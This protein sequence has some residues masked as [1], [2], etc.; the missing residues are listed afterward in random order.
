M[1]AAR[2]ASGAG[3]AAPA[4]VGPGGIAPRGLGLA[5]LA[6]FLWSLTGVLLRFVEA[7]STWQIIGLRSLVMLAAIALYLV[8]HHRGGVLRAI[9]AIGREGLIGGLCLGCGFAFYISAIQTTTVAN[10]AMLTAL[11]PL[12]AAVLARVI[13]GEAVA[14]RTWLYAAVAVLG[15]GAMVAE[16]AVLGGWLGNLLAL[17]AVACQAAF[18]VA[19][20]K[21]RAVD[22]MPA[23]GV[24]ALVSAAFALA[25]AGSVAV[26]TRD[27]GLI[28]VTGI[29]STLLGNLAFVRAAR[30]VGAATLALLSMAEIVMSPLWVA[31]LV[32]ELPTPWA[33]AGGALVIGAVLAQV[34]DAAR[35]SAPAPPA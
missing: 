20:R 22:M 25:M 32:S 23:I 27:L 34:L 8:A 16:G 30:H 13:L 35:G 19:V 3:E 33:V 1:A 26:T 18:T 12:V 9:A 11:V 7:A 21:G 24:A 31:L 28:A 15:A 5:L 6:A 14:A 29:V 2:P 10:V 17:G 4:R